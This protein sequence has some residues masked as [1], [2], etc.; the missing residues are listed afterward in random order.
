MKTLSKII[1]K[2]ENIL[3]NNELKN[4]KGGDW[5]GWCWVYCGGA[6]LQG[7]AVSTSEEAAINTLESMYSWC[8]P[9]PS[10]SCTEI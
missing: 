7:P 4:I 1:I 3:K 6:L 5:E 8:Q 2:D 10:V 9:G